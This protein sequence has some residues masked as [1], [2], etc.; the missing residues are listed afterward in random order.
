MEKNR[1]D[2][3]PTTA[4]AAAFKALAKQFTKEKLKENVGKAMSV[5][6]VVK[7]FKDALDVCVELYKGWEVDFIL[8][9]INSMYHEGKLNEKDK[10][11]N[12]TKRLNDDATLSLFVGHCKAVADQSNSRMAKIMLAIYTGKV[13]TSPELVQDPV[14]GVIIDTLSSVN[15]FNLRHLEDMLKYMNEYAQQVEVQRAY[16]VIANWHQVQS[17]ERRKGLMDFKASMRKFVNIGILDLAS[18]GVSYTSKMI[19]QPN[20]YSPMIFELC[21][22]YHELYERTQEEPSK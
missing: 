1:D 11:E 13:I 19:V 5:T 22:E 20:H 12:L 14:S 16:S 21:Q 15:D 2:H 17:P 8:E 10:I 18:G 7:D 4:D 3:T 6:P 9:L